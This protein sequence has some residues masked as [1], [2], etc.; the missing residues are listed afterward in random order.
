MASGQARGYSRGMDRPLG[1]WVT[2][3][4]G[5]VL[6]GLGVVLMA[7]NPWARV[8][9]YFLVSGLIVVAVAFSTFRRRRRNA[10]GS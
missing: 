3:A 7:V 2:L 5:V 4:L 1:P 9:A 10:K 8:G 6:L